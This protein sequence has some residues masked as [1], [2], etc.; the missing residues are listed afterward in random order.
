MATFAKYL[1]E[2]SIGSTVVF[3]I[4]TVFLRGRTFFQL[5]R[6]F[7]VGGLAISLVLPFISLPANIVHSTNAISPIS[8]D[9][10]HTEYIP[11]A[12]SNGVDAIN[13]N[14]SKLAAILYV[15]GV[16]FFVSRFLL[17]IFNVLQLRNQSVLG[18]I[19]GAKVY[20]QESVPTFSFFNLIF[21]SRH[22]DIIVVRHEQ[23]HVKQLHSIDNVFIEIISILL[24]INPL[25]IFYK[26][27]LKN[28]HEFLADQGAVRNI[29]IEVYI[30]CLLNATLT[31]SRIPILTS[32]FGSQLIKNRVIMLTKSKTPLYKTMLYLLIVPAVAVLLFA[33]QDTPTTALLPNNTVVSGQQATP[34]GPPVEINKI[35]NT[36][37]FGKRLHPAT[38][39]M[40]HH[41]GV[42]LGADEGV[43]V[44]ATADGVVVETTFNDLKGNFVVIRHGDQFTTQYYHLL[45]ST[46]TK[47]ATVKKGDVIGH[48]GST[49]VLSTN[50]HLHYEV[51]KDG[52]AVNP[53]DYLPTG[54]I[55]D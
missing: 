26:R 48:V 8:M 15:A 47:G 21:T 18:H 45:K 34:D 23:V 53:V 14:L 7:L 25:M 38:K 28:E 22:T 55:K 10:I 54:Y 42:D 29:D 33:F 19:H 20:L 35:K 36:I 37:G 30:K 2:V 13:Y 46:V 3:L 50:N 27:A 49:G 40:T 5:N 31:T 39:K 52:K 32:H 51:L 16:L 43:D 1:L 6:F 41:S 24:W 44:V 17:G 9:Q 11:L 4:Y 12:Y